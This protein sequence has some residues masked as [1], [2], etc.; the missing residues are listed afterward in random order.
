MSFSTWSR[1]FREHERPVRRIVL[2][3]AG[4]IL[5]PV[6]WLASLQAGFDVTYPACWW[7]RRSL[8]AATV[9]MPIPAMALIAWLIARREPLRRRGELPHDEEPWPMWLAS[10]G[11][12]T[13]GFFVLVTLTM[14]APVIGLDPC[15]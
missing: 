5:V 8:L 11:L 13:C 12:M 3:M 15:G 7:G 6:L 1:D 4:V 9:L 2:L 14:I 10:L